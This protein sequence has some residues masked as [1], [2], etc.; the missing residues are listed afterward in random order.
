MSR[1]ISVLFVTMVVASGCTGA[2]GTPGPAGPPGAEGPTGP[3]GEPGAPL[4]DPSLSPLDKAFAAIGG[5]DA[6]LALDTIAIEATGSRRMSLEGYHPDDDSVEVS[7]FELS[8]VADL[9]DDALR[10]DWQ[11][12][13]PLFGAMPAFSQILAGDVGYT[14]GFESVWG[15]PGGDMPSDRWAAVRKQQRLLNPQLI[16]RELA[17]DASGAIDAGVALLDGALHHLVV[18]ADAVSP[19]TLYVSATTGR[20]AKLETVENDYVTSDTRL[21]VFYAGWRRWDGDVLFPNDVVITL[22]GHVV[23]VEHRSSVALNGT[24]DPASLAL[25]EGAMPAHVEADAARGERNHQFH[26]EFSSIGVPLDGLQTY[27]DA[28]ELA[29]GVYQLAGGSHHSLAIEQ[30]GGVVIAE[31]PLYPARAEAILAWVAATFPG[32]SVTHVIATHHHRDHAGSLRSFVAAGATVVVGEASADFFA[33]SFRRERTIDPD[34]L[35]AT[36]REAT[37]VAVPPGGSYVIDDPT[38]PVAAHA[39][40]TAHASDMLVVHA[41]AQRVL[42]NSDLYSPGAP[43]VPFFVAELSAAIAARGLAVDTMA[44]GHGFGTS[45]FAE[46]QALVP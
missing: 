45:T 7:T 14:E 5:R 35:A 18:V 27:V 43:P 33:R 19:I 6:L 9:S 29:P 11:R 46:F 8:L 24:I 2:D 34:A 10:L 41:P 1:A 40:E 13:V 39:I 22:G 28:Q 20:I 23:H 21:E 17:E 30:A 16:L 37:I 32:K 42:F 26:E 3:M 36:P 31:A 38:H 4:V 44:G 15:T 25:P 12:D